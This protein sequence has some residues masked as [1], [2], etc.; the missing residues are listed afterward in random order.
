MRRHSP[1]LP[2]AFAV[3][4]ALSA[5]PGISNAATE[6]IAY[7]EIVRFAITATPPPPGSFAADYATLTSPQSTAQT[8][9]PKRGLFGGIDLRGL[10]HSVA[11]GTDPG[12]AVGDVANQ[13]I[14]NAKDAAI[15]NAIDGMLANAV[16]PVARQF[17]SLANGRLEH[18]AFYRT[19][20]RV[21]DV[22]AN[23]ATILKCDRHRRIVLDLAR[24][25]YRIEDPSAPVSAGAPPSRGC[26]GQQTT[27]APGTG[28]LSVTSDNVAL[29]SQTIDGVQ[30][31]GVRS[32]NA[33]AI[34]NATGSCKN[35]SFTV[36]STAYYAPYRAPRPYCP[37]PAALRHPY[38]P[39]ELATSS[40]PSGCHLRPYVRVRSAATAPS[41]RLALY[42][43]LSMNAGQ[44]AG[45]HPMSFVIERGNVR[46]LSSADAGLFDIPP[47]FTLAK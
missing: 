28:T 38:S 42:E 2:A 39:S 10:A 25:T 11:G 6:N 17:E 5:H 9:A 29:G 24:K 46:S 12:S 13:S 43:L 20:E 23:T 19:W 35:G 3:A 40:D 31:T 27:M 37:L 44:D 15:D 30:A 47:G 45:S 1:L 32:T 16:R 8:A 18:H 33:I 4:C 7:D 26:T 14:S 36:S 41:G 22:A 34:E 21:D